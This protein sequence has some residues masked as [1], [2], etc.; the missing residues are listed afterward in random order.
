MSVAR[1]VP[2]SAWTVKNSSKK[3]KVKICV[4]HVLIG[5]LSNYPFENGTW[6]A[7]H[8]FACRFALKVHLAM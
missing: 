5:H 1:W 6:F 2:R 4:I 8:C 3:V 7:I